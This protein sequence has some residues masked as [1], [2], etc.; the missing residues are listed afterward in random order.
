MEDPVYADYWFNYLRECED[1]EGLCVEERIEE[2]GV[3]Q[4]RFR[5]KSME[6][7][8]ASPIPLNYFCEFSVNLDY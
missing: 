5:F 7:G 3:E 2:G 6:D 1:V 8:V 4:Y